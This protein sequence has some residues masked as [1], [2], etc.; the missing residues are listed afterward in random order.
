MR[1][2]GI[3]TGGVIGGNGED[4]TGEGVDTVEE[5]VDG[6]LY[7]EGWWRTLMFR[8]RIKKQRDKKQSEEKTKNE[9]N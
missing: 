7:S 8:R 6:F 4:T 3:A 5:G 9:V 2:S 1:G